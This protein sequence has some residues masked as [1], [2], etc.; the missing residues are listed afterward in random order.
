[1]PLLLRDL[2]SLFLILGILFKPSIQLYKEAL[3]KKL[4]KDNPFEN[5]EIKNGYI[6]IENNK[7]IHYLYVKS[8]SNDINTPVVIAEAGGPGWST[9]SLVM[10]GLGVFTSDFGEHSK[11]E[12]LYENVYSVV[13]FADLQLIETPL[14]GGCSYWED[15]V[16]KSVKEI[17]DNKIK[18][19]NNFENIVNIKE[20]D[21]YLYPISFAGAT[22]V[23]LGLEL[24][25]MGYKIK[26]VFAD[27]I[28]TNSHSMMKFYTKN[29]WENNSINW[30]R[31][32]YYDFM[33]IQSSQMLHMNIYG[34]GGLMGQLQN[35][36]IQDITGNYIVSPI[37]VRKGMLKFVQNYE[38]SQVKYL[39]DKKIY[40]NPG[41]LNCKK[42]KPFHIDVT[43]TAGVV[44]WVNEARNSYNNIFGELLDKNIP[45][46]IIEG[47]YDFPLGT[48][49]Q[50]DWISQ[51][52][53]FENI[54]FSK[55]TPWVE[56]EFGRKKHI[57]GKFLYLEVANAGHAVW[58][59]NSKV[60]HDSLKDFIKNGI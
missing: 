27:S 29:L 3:G 34:A 7:H 37:D 6:E 44:L 30:V 18:F 1:M 16:T 38:E 25:N 24:F 23:P 2:I 26:G 36:P 42:D 33:G 31:Y 11:G 58:I 60:A 35:A 21:L 12:D 14:N 48:D 28:Y 55:K 45:L 17:V 50:F 43:Q 46:V 5:Y 22:Q 59:S 51:V 54:G 39:Q 13:N 4:D 15:H 56:Q 57:P 19:F 53:Q 32:F 8:K 49:F 9:V 20:R 52:K 47:K 41:I 40:T 10:H